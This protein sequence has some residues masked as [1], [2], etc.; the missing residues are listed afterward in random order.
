ME[1]ELKELEDMI[2]YTFRDKDLLRLSLTHSSY[3]KG[4]DVFGNERL[5]FVG[6]AILDLVIA[7]ALFELYPDRDE[8]WLTQVRSGLVDDQ[9]LFAKAESLGLGEYIVLGKGEA[10]Q[11]GRTKPSILSGA[12]ESLVGAIFL[13]GGYEACESFVKSEFQSVLIVDDDHDPKNAKSVL[14][15][16][17]QKES[18][19]LPKYEVISEEG[20]DHKRKFVVA[21]YIDGVEKG[22]GEGRSKK[23]AEMAAASSA[24][25][26][27]E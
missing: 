16:I 1:K 15:E 23:E 5:E 25:D 17:V 24:L 14:Q 22:R 8:G 2:K 3:V 13:D 10:S 26:I 9:T 27:E 19:D 12:Y 4:E 18:G 11:G 20:P 6:D 21:V 7:K